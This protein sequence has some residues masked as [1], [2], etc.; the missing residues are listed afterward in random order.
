MEHG[1]TSRDAL[2]G[3][4]RTG[5]RCGDQAGVGASLRAMAAVGPHDG[6]FQVERPATARDSGQWSA[7]RQASSPQRLESRHSGRH[8][9]L[10]AW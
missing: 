7:K 5:Q 9:A 3:G 2:A 1:C 4:A 6:V 8:Y 10:G